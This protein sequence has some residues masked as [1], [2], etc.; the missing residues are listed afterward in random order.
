ML[1]VTF[2]KYY[3][4]HF[5]LKMSLMFLKSFKRYEDFFF[6]FDHFDPVFGFF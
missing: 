6:N 4:S 1:F 5:S 2:N 3:K